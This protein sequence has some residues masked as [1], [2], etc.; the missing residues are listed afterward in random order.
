MQGHGKQP[1]GWKADILGPC[2][3]AG[4]LG[5]RPACRSTQ[6][7]AL[8]RD[9]RHWGRPMSTTALMITSIASPSSAPM[10]SPAKLTPSSTAT[11]GLT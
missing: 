8:A 5:W 11:T 2:G 10:C 6:A 9:G 7:R 4:T 1:A 3:L